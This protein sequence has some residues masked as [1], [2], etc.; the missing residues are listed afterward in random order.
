MR[1]MLSST[2]GRIMA[3]RRTQ[4]DS[5]FLTMRHAWIDSGVLTMRH[6]GG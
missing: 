3:A 2:S 6:T 4:V 1:C 5:G